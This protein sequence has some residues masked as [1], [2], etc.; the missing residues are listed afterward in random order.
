LCRADASQDFTALPKKAG[1]VHDA[2]KQRLLPSSSYFQLIDIT[3]PGD[4]FKA[5][6][7]LE[8]TAA[9]M[10]AAFLSAST[11]F[12]SSGAK[13]T[14]MMKANPKLT[15]M[16]NH[17]IAAE[18]LGII[19]YLLHHGMVKGMNASAFS[20]FFTSPSI[21][22]DRHAEEI[23]ERFSKLDVRPAIKPAPISVGSNA[24][25]MR[26]TD[27]GAEDEA[28]MQYKTMI[29]QAVSGGDHTTKRLFEKIPAA[30]EG[31]HGTLTILLA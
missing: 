9:R 27:A 2:P 7:R 5:I 3:L 29:K 1:S 19:E 16:M 11:F 30:G 21:D 12:D 10:A 13:G 23:A 20:G 4:M 15:E 25:R 18:L 28:I 8:Q 6:D 22:E 14:G 31:R 17:G 26:E 24:V